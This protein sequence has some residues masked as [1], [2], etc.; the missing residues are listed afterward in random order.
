M[1]KIKNKHRKDINDFIKEIEDP[2]FKK[3]LMDFNKVDSEKAWERVCS[4]TT[5]LKSNIISRRTV[6]YSI[7]AIA[8][9]L[10]IF[11][12]LTL[13]V[14]E[15]AIDNQ[16]SI[17]RI[18]YGDVHI[19]DHNNSII[20]IKGNKGNKQIAEVNVSE[21]V[22]AAQDSSTVKTKEE[23]RWNTIVVPKG[24]KA[25]IKL[26]DGTV[27]WLNADSK[28]IYPVNFLGDH[29]EVELYGEG[30]FIVTKDKSKPFIVRNSELMI[31]VLGTKFNIS[32]WGNSEKAD[33]T[34]VSG[35]VEVKANNQLRILEPN[36]K[37]SL[38]KRS[39]AINISE[40]D[41][42]EQT[43]WINDVV[44]LR[45]TSLS[46]IA[47]TLDRWYGVNVLFKE[48]ALKDI[49]IS[50][51]ICKSDD[52]KVI[53]EIICKTAKLNWRNTSNNGEVLIYE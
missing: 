23:M 48:D 8:A 19:I 9:T 18:D 3:S 44:Y 31:K 26:G 33:V 24:K 45:S 34:L 50:G 4:E 29:R 10:L 32:N 22:N 39:G 51:E 13:F 47:K 2:V 53:I 30:Y 41:P 36:D 49:R 52:P 16:A 46:N 38:E 14:P 15:K 11:Y 42:N 7:A 28:M 25:R 27:V 17:E 43:S 40:V 1:D 5:K 37:F 35:S 6:S 12:F 20:D 21:Y